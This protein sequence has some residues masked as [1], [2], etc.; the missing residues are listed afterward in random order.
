MSAPTRRTQTVVERAK[1]ALNLLKAKKM[2]KQM[3]VDM[4]NINY[5]RVFTERRVNGVC[6]VKY[7]R[8]KPY[9]AGELKRYFKRTY[10]EYEVK[11]SNNIYTRNVTIY[12]K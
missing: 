5:L 6:R 2:R 10:P 8:I 4:P 7:W 3:K 9:H 12:I 1:Y 11:I